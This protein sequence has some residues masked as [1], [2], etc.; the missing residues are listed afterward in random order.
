MPGEQPCIWLPAISEHD[1]G[2]DAFAG[3]QPKG[4][5]GR[6]RF[7]VLQMAA[8]AVL[9]NDLPGYLRD[10][11]ERNSRQLEQTVQSRMLDREARKSRDR[12]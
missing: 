8:G 10:S 1:D 9:S 2:S 11:L 7:A 3:P 5:V 4:S 12:S 6:V